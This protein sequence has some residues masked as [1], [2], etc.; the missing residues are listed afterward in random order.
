M[1][2]SNCAK[3][4][5]RYQ[6]LLGAIA[7][8]VLIALLTAPIQSQQAQPSN[9]EQRSKAWIEY[10]EACLKL[11]EADLAET[12]NQNRQFKRSASEYDL[13]RL[14]LHRN[15]LQNTLSIVRQSGDYGDVIARYAEMHAKLAELD[16][17]LAEESR[18]KD[19]ASIPDTQYER[20]RRNAEVYRLQ[21]ALIRDPASASSMIDHLHWEAHRLTAEVMLLNR[22]VERLEEFAQR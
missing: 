4:N 19:P 17:K 13:Q 6:I 16:V 9:D 2:F 5:C 7:L 8:G 20:I 14:R 15:L 11:A 21:V 12:E 1:S 3:F 22:R 18:Q 10:T